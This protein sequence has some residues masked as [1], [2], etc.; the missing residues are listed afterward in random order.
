M[1]RPE[2]AP[3]RA[4]ASRLPPGK[5][6]SRRASCS[7]DN[8]TDPLWRLIDGSAISG[9]CKCRFGDGRERAARGTGVEFRAVAD[10]P[11]RLLGVGNAQSIIFLRWAWRLAERGHE[12]H[13]V[14]DRI[15]ERREE[16]KGLTVHDVRDLTWVTRVKGLRRFGFGPAV[17][18]LAERLDV[19]LVHAHYLLPYGW[20]GAWAGVHPLVMSPW[21]T[22][23]YTYGRERRRGRKR[24]RMAIAAGDEFVVSSLANAEETI[25]LG[26][27]REK[28]NRIV[29]YVDLRPFGPEH[30][31]PALRARLGWP[32]DS[33]VVLSLRNYR[34]NTN[35]DVL[36]RAFSRVIEEVP[37][38]AADP[39]GARRVGEGGDRRSAGRARLARS[40]RPGL[41]EAG[42]AADLLRVR[43]YRRLDRV[44]R[45]DPGIH[46]RVDGLAAP[47]GH[48]RRSDHRR[49]DHAG[50]GRR[51][52]RLSRRGRDHRGAA[53]SC[54]ATPSC[55]ASTAS[56]TSAWC[57]SGSATPASSWRPS[58]GGFSTIERSEAE[59]PPPRHRLPAR[60]HRRAR[61]PRVA[62]DEQA[63]VGGARAS[64]RR[65][66][67]ARRR[68]RRSRRC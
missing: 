59:L 68:A 41:R 60:G 16:L 28:V 12:V 9:V 43:R 62:G 25:R 15:T 50:R 7:G 65:T 13:V 54:C 37:A 40:R 20:W 18:G 38:G 8:N 5:S 26:A 45:R 64:R 4:D 46:G 61:T 6:S 33:L 10:R 2:D 3:P 24:V 53:A 22:D 30:R 19:D 44:H 29:W 32:E 14:S 31:D 51:G 17:R 23:I 56:G 52:R 57:A 36:V 67:P 39:R 48:G 1:V 11:L 35:L 42:R 34:P 58:I 55:A 49:V 66:R 63:D 27:P 21:N 47:D